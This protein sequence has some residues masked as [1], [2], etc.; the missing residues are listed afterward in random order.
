MMLDVG[1]QFEIMW[2]FILKLM[3]INWSVAAPQS[4]F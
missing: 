2:I 4:T 3:V 1:V